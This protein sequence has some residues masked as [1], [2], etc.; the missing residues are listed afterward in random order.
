MWL[1]LL[2][3]FIYS[4]LIFFFLLSSILFFSFSAD[5]SRERQRWRRVRERE[6]LPSSDL[7]L[8]AGPKT[9]R[10]LESSNRGREREELQTNNQGKRRELWREFSSFPLCFLFYFSGLQTVSKRGRIAAGTNRKTKRKREEDFQQREKQR[11]GKKRRELRLCVCKTHR[12]CSLY[13]EDLKGVDYSCT[14]FDLRTEI[15]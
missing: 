12:P 7:L 5:E 4:L 15:L 2:F 13:V 11:M 8:A 1:L 6:K 14:Y 10:E 9:E 3:L